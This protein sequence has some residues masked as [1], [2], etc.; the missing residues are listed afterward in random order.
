MKDTIQIFCENLGKYVNV[1]GG[2]TLLEVYL[3]LKDEIKIHPL[4]AHVNNK[5]E[6]LG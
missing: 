1:A 6:G 3:R 5:T 4:C 2:E